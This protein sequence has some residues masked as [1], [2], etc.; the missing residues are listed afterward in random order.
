MQQWVFSDPAFSCGWLTCVFVIQEQGTTPAEC[1][2]HHQPR[3]FQSQRRDHGEQEG[4]C[5]RGVTGEKE[6]ST[7]FYSYLA[8]VRLM[9]LISAKLCFCHG[10]LFDHQCAFYHA[11]ATNLVFNGSILLLWRSFQ[12]QCNPPLLW[13]VHWFIACSLICW[14]CALSV[15]VRLWKEIS[16]WGYP[17][18]Q[19]VLML[20]VL[21]YSSFSFKLP[22]FSLLS[23]QDKIW[24]CIQKATAAANIKSI[25]EIQPL[26][27]CLR[28]REQINGEHQ[29][30]WA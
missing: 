17:F 15:K 3:T 10:N 29:L 20:E 13:F 30:H 28:R 25:S 1:V 27:W 23:Y 8:F 9:G 5:P 7:N 12:M 6:Q 14:K 18:G 16:W 19:Y 11:I 22:P 21:C 4:S 2:E 26:R 24:C